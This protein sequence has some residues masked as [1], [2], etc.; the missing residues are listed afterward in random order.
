MMKK[1]LTT[2]ILVALIALPVLAENSNDDERIP[3]AVSDTLAG[4]ATSWEAGLSGSQAS[5][6]NWAQ[7]GINNIAAIGTSDFIAKYRE[8][9]FSYG[10][11]LNTRFGQTRIEDEGVRKIDDRL[12]A[13]N[14]FLY[15]IG[16]E[17]GDFKIFANIN[18]RTQ[19]AEGYN[20]GAGED[21]EDI[22][23]SRFM[24]P[25]YLSENIGLAYIP[26][27]NF[28]FEAG[29]GMLQTFVRDESLSTRYG[30][31]EGDTFRN[32]AGVT[33]GATYNMR[34]ATNVSV[35]TSLETFT[36]VNK[37]VKST[38][39]L[40]NSQLT[41]R[42]NNYMNASFRLDLVYDDDFSKELQVAQILSVGVSF[43]LI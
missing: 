24:A 14:R 38:N 43:I 27:D 42:I 32:E 4:W 29:F 10:F 23:T 11:R 19:F 3:P 20:Y 16:D 21:G 22:L 6:S 25:G 7:G 36:N 12:E 33:F 15:D 30:L 2:T 9:R 28:S 35:N 31:E 13:L 26:T 37:S 40:F 17:G 41:G 1:L 18:F 5:Y 39:V 34:V 8:N